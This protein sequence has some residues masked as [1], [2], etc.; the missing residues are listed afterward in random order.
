LTLI[1]PTGRTL[2]SRIAEYRG[3]GTLLRLLALR[4]IRLRYRQT[5]LGIGWA[6]LQPLLP[7][8][9]FAAVFSRLHFDTGGIPYPLFVFSGFAPWIFIGNAVTNASPTFVNNFEMI[10]KVYFPRAVLPMAVVA[11]LALDGAVAVLCAVALS[12]WYGY[13]PVWSWLLLPLVGMV[14]VMVAMAAAV[15]AASLTAVLRDIKNAIPFLVQLW[16][17]ASPVLYPVEWIPSAL[18]RFAGFN[19]ITGLLTAFRACLFGVAPDWEILAQSGIS[20][21]MLMV[22]AVEIFRRLEADLA[23][24]I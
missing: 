18:R 14:A 4:D 13:G 23:E 10:N 21:V 19:P 6:V 5:A 3:S 15:A 12:A 9:I 2:R 1:E 22:A 7:M 16:M 20:I 8:L 17:Y 24:R 11:A